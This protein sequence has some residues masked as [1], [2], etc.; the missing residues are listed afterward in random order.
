ME[1]TVEA[2]ASGYFVALIDGRRRPGAFVNEDV[3][4]C[5]FSIEAQTILDMQVFANMRAGGII[6]PILMSDL[7]PYLDQ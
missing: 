6:G 1:Q 4:R 3:A 2:H 5:S 7:T